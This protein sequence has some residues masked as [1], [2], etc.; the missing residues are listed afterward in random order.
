M[1]PE[2]GQITCLKTLTL[3]TVGKKRGCHLDELKGLNL[4]GT[5]SIKHLQRV[6][7]PQDAKEANLVEKLNLRRLS[8]SWENDSDLQSQEDVEKVLE[9]LQPHTNLKRLEIS[10][11]KGD[12]FPSWSSWMRDNI[13]NNNVVYIEISKCDN[14]SQLPPLALLPSL[15]TLHLSNMSRVMYIDDHFQGDGM[16]SGFPSLQSL[17][18]Q[19][20]PSLQRFSRE[21]GRE[22][23]PRLTSLRIV[24]CPELTLPHLPSV[25][26]LTIKECN[27]VVLG[28]ISN[29]KNLISLEVSFNNELNYL[30]EGTLLNLTSL[31]TLEIGGFWKLKC[32][33][34]EIGSLSSLETLEIYFCDEL[35][36]FPEQGMEGLKSLKYLTLAYCPELVALPDGMKYLTS[37]HHLQLSGSKSEVLPDVL[38]YVPALQSLEISGYPNLESL[39]HWLGDLTSL[40]TL[41]IINCPKLSTVPASIKG[42]TS[43]QTLKIMYCLKLRSLPASIQGLTMLQNLYIVES[44]E[45]EKRIEKEKGEDWYKI[46][47]IPNVEE[48]IGVFP[49]SL[50]EVLLGKAKKDKKIDITQLPKL[51]PLFDGLN[52]FETLIGWSLIFFFLLSGTCLA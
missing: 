34:T 38:R 48:F 4:G 3:F 42:L 49:V 22:L 6:E 5:L 27:E 13:R 35:E 36:S 50:L 33:P 39:P 16:A 44:P 8:L 37:L 14:C 45:L 31:K 29:L 26:Q 21:D 2:I 7:N 47:H 40:Q 1:P 28:S 43:L 46:A 9:A 41:R 15:R 32:L 24:K 12:Q 23:L 11:Y 17:I 30:P 25:E 18:I 20:L 19:N 51:A 52:C 10:G